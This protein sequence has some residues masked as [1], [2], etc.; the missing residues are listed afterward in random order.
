[1]RWQW[2]RNQKIHK[3]TWT[4]YWPN[5]NKK[6][7]SEWNLLPTP[8]D[9]NRPF[10]GCN[11]QGETIHFDKYGNLLRTYHFSDGILQETDVVTK[12]N[13]VKFNKIK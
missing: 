9:L 13:V 3:G 7:I 5:G 1:M 10:I 8:R 12:K 11:A 2:E 4:H 6:L